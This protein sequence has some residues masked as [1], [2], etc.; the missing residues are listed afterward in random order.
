MHTNGLTFQENSATH[1]PPGTLALFKHKLHWK[2]YIPPG[3]KEQPS[4]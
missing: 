3:P 1:Q 2:Q 4:K